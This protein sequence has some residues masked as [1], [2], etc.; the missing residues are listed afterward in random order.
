[1]VTI[2]VESPSKIKKVR[3]YAEN[4]LKDKVACVASL[5]HIG[6]FSKEITVDDIK[7]FNFSYTL[8]K[9]KL[10]NLKNILSMAQK[11]KAIYIA[12]DPDREGEAIGFRLKEYLVRNKI[13]K[14]KIKRINLNE[15]TLDGV[16]KAFKNVTDINDFAV[17]AQITRAALDQITGFLT[18]RM[19]WQALSG[20]NL[21]AGRVQIPALRFINERDTIIANFRPEPYINIVLHLNKNNIEFTAVRRFKN[22][23]L[24]TPE[25]IYKKYQSLKK[26]KVLDVV[27]KKETIP[28]PAPYHTQSA[29]SD[30]VKILKIPVKTAQSVLQSLYEKGFITYHR[31]DSTRVSDE[32]VS[33]AK[34]IINK[35][36]KSLFEAHKG[37]SGEQDAHEAIR[38]THAIEDTS[39][40]NDLERKVYNLIRD[41]FIISQMKPAVVNKTIVTFE[42][43][44]K[45]T[46]ISII[47]AGFLQY[48]K[49]KQDESILPKLIEGDIVNIEKIDK[50]N[51]ETQPPDHY[52]VP[53][54]LSKLKSTGIGRPSTYAY[55]IDTL[56][57]REYV[58]EI[59]G[60]LYQTEKG[61]AVID[62]LFD[63]YPVK[64]VFPEFTAEMERLLDEIATGKHSTANIKEYL[65]NLKIEL[66][67]KLKE[68]SKAS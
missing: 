20:M 54:L 9:K 40:L 17:R 24:K 33:I 55:I 12:T 32:G 29:Q 35:I 3:Q 67:G 5:G 61:K 23:D 49:R 68:L 62:F 34:D 59:K 15:I 50:E 41:R 28:S 43:E 37:K 6:S 13:S 14:D 2:I 7:K 4:V 16:K 1:M 31:T 45:A 36:D 44:F 39:E 56:L 48:S 10:K 66:D 64:Y 27:S 51:K 53:I 42:D 38:V 8:D 11:S 63:S 52:T 25:Q 47:Y 46:G 57:K 58:K 60:K 21:S 18:S 30:I 19:L 65:L 22:N 26:I